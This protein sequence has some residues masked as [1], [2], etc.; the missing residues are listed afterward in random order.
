MKMKIRK[1]RRD[2]TRN[3]IANQ[4]RLDAIAY[5]RINKSM[6]A[7]MATW[8]GTVCPECHKSIPARAFVIG[9]D[10]WFSDGC[11]VT[12]GTS[13]SPQYCHQDVMRCASESAKQDKQQWMFSPL[14]DSTLFDGCAKRQRE[15]VKAKQKENYE[16]RKS[17]N[18]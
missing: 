12:V 4:K 17:Q 16:W 9:G 10:V 8:G 15:R 2:R 11:I 5:A 18:D 3:R 13:V 6:L 7:S 14:Y 1:R